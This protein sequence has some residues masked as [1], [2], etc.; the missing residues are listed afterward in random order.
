MQYKPV[1][2]LKDNAKDMLRGKYNAAISICIMSV[3]VSLAANLFIEGNVTPFF[4]RL[5]T[6]PETFSAPALVAPFLTSEIISFLA[7]SVLGL[8]QLGS[9]LFFMN[10][11]CNR[12]FAL[13][14]L[15]YAFRQDTGR[16]LAVSVIQAL[17]QTICL[18]PFRFFFT[19]YSYTKDTSWLTKAMIAMAIGYC[20]YI[21]VS[22]SLHLVLKADGCGIFRFSPSADILQNFPDKSAVDILKLSIRTMNGHKFRLFLL[23][24]SFVPLMLLCVCTLYIGFLWLM[25]YMQMTYVYFFLDVMNPENR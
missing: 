8:L 24:L 10:M 15:F 16:A 13:N 6:L 9:T 20:I 1:Y 5:F 22:L 11:A 7:A 21:P 18:I 2:Q 12:S 25:P 14:N 17:I 3:M 4:S 19:C 23:E